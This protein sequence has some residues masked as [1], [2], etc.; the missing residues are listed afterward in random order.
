MNQASEVVVITGG[1]A[2][3]GRATVRRF[4]RAKAKIGVLAR[5]NE[6]LG[7]ARAEVEQLG[8]EAIAIPTDVAYADQ[9]EAAAEKVEQA[10]GPIDIWVNNAM[11]TVFSPFLEVTP[12]EFKRATEVTYLG[13]VYGTMSALKRMVP[14]ER[15]VVVQVG[16]AL[17]YRSIPLQSAYCGA[18][19]AIRGFTDSVR[20]E[21]L[22]RKSKVHITMVQMPGLNTP[23]FNW[24]ETKLPN[25]PQPVPPIFQP[26]VAADAIYYA[27][28][29]HRREM[30]VG[31]S[32]V[33]AIVANKLVPSVLDWYLAK[34]G[35]KSQQTNEPSPPHRQSNLFHPLSGDPG[36]HG[37]FD[38]LA[39]SASPQLWANTHRG[40]AAL[41]GVAI[42]AAAGTAVFKL[43]NN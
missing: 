28:H 4:A 37:N 25:H 6:A 20:T 33:K 14:R 13:F 32:T 35:F 5:G 1:S 24:C 26:E 7:A 3:V 30:Y 36:A 2:G 43:R 17:A 29:H 10:F 9:V 39:E 8:G 16:S 19:A 41:I 31:R 12:E 21:L 15:G 22:H 27:A 40:W 42:G 11:T 38:A 34:T 18:K 23:Q